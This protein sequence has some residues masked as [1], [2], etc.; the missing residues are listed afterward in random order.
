MA[1]LEKKILLDTTLVLSKRQ[2]YLFFLYQGIGEKFAEEGA[3]F[4][5]NKL[6][7]SPEWKNFY[8]VFGGH[9]SCVNDI[10]NLGLLC[11]FKNLGETIEDKD[12]YYDYLTLKK[13]VVKSIE[14]ELVDVD[15]KYL[16]I[17]GE[18]PELRG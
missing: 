4:Y 7:D 8:S 14:L 9:A 12:V 13:H 1:I 5:M 18:T 15:K 17:I 11:Y 6:E 3:E 2:L 16:D 10:F